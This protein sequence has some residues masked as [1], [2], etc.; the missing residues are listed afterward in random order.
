MNALN[1]SLPSLEEEA[2]PATI[3]DVDVTTMATGLVRAYGIE[4]AALTATE[5]ALAGLDG[6]NLSMARTWR[7]VLNA[8][9]RCEAREP[10]GLRLEPPRSHAQR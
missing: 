3:G 5:R 9:H 4:A 8:V 2:A 7:Q 6:G 1:I 10:D